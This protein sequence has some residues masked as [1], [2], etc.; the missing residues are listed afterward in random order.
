MPLIDKAELLRQVKE[1]NYT[2]NSIKLIER[3]KEVNAIPLDMIWECIQRADDWC[4]DKDTLLNLIEF[5]E[6][7]K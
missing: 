5:W 7:N 1:K 2:A 4:F 3:Q 6:D